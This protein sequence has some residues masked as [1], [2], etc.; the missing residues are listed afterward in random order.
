MQIQNHRNKSHLSRAISLPGCF[1]F[2]LF[3]PGGTGQAP[4]QDD[5]Q[6]EDDN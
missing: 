5:D 2:F 1:F 6:N 3:S 4:C